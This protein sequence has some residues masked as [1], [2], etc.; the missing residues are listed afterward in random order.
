[1][2][3][4]TTA[5]IATFLSLSAAQAQDGSY[6]SEQAARACI[7]ARLIELVAQERPSNIAGDTALN[8]CTNELRAEFKAKKK[9][10]CEAVA[11][12]GWLVADENSKLNGLPGQTYR[13]DKSFIQ[14]CEKS[15]N[16]DKH[17]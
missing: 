12:T 14:S 5:A 3:R 4:V 11:Y 9:T 1:M 2:R 17:R 6:T 8:V 16:W 10:Y 15:E 13:P 7:H